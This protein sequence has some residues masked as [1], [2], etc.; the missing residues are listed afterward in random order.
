M[1]NIMGFDA[2]NKE[3]QSAKQINIIGTN[4]RYQI[5]K[6]TKEPV[7]NKKRV[8]S[9][10]WNFSKKMFTTDTQF[11]VLNKILNNEVFVSL[12]EIEE[13]ES[14]EKVIAQQISKKINGYKQQDLLKKIYDESQFITFEHVVSKLVDSKLNCYY[15]QD[16]MIILYDITRE[17][18]QWSIDRI[19]NE[20]GHNVGN[21][22]LACLDCNLKRRRKSDEK[23]KFTK[24]LN[25]VKQN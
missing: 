6:L 13:I 25:I 4:N 14:V 23:F 21:F 22:H 2:E 19:D 1:N 5:K 12:Q 8:E 16:K 20:I 3:D 17:I 9:E 7:S 24:Q 11:T 15:C 10:K 18:K